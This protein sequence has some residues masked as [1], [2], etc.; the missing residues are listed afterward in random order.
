MTLNAHF[1]LFSYLAPDHD[2]MSCQCLIESVQARTEALERELQSYRGHMDA[3]Q[4]GDF[5][6]A[7]EHI[8]RAHSS[9]AAGFKD[10]RMSEADA[11][12]PGAAFDLTSTS[13]C[14][15]VPVHGD[16]S[17]LSETTLTGAFTL[18]LA[19]VPFRLAPAAAA[20]C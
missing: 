10:V 5:R 11:D 1:L 15:A 2:R 20:S 12:P 8:V 13:V 17:D 19:A 4:R 9:S 14:H 16:S 18:A 7:S 3:L 6:A